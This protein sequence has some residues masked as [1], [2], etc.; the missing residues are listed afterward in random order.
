MFISK[1]DKM[2]LCLNKVTR[3]QSKYSV[4]CLIVAIQKKLLRQS[5]DG[6]ILN[7]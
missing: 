6:I 2:Y 5:G 4:N 3:N 1:S 7:K